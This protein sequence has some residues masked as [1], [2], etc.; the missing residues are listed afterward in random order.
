MNVILNGWVWLPTEEIRG[1]AL[2]NLQE[3]LTKTPR[4]PRDFAPDDGTD[5]VQVYVERDGFIGV[6]RAYFFETAQRQHDIHDE[7]SAGYVI[8]ESRLAFLGATSGH[9]K[10]DEHSAVLEAV[11]QEY[12]HGSV[13]GVVKAVPAWGKTGLAIRI[14]CAIGHKTF[15]GVHKEFLVKQWQ[16]RLEKFAPY[17]RVGLW[18]GKKEEI[19]DKDVVIGMVQTLANRDV[20]AEIAEQFGL[21]VWDE[22]HRVS[23]RTWCTVPPKFNPR[24][25]LGLSAKTKRA[26]GMEDLFRWLVGPVIYEAQYQTPLPIIRRIPTPYIRPEWIRKKEDGEGERLK[27]PTHLKA[28]TH[29]NTR[30]ARIVAELE[31]IL[32]ARAG[33]KIVVM[34]ERVKHLETMAEM[35]RDRDLAD[36]IPDLSMGFVHS[37]ISEGAKKDAERKRVIFATFQ[38]FEEGFDLPSLDTLVMTTARGDVEQ[39]IGRVRRECI[40]GQTVTEEECKYYCPWRAGRCRSKPKPVA[41]E[42][43]DPDVASVMGKMKYRDRY[44]RSIGAKVLEAGG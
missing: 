29:S 42:F 3:S 9:E 5:P 6:P 28:M 8:E 41:V 27:Y 31:T 20:P 12:A 37:K 7:R 4:V 2:V 40:A 24:F 26:D 13:G 43:T 18:Q 15:V 32:R 22:V 33:R 16:D 34:S 23:A 44:Y 25:H 10:W 21:C 17:L 1:L 30:N 11:K 39:A 35:L 36:P 19:E 38:I 14:I